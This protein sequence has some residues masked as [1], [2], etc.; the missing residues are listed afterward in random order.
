MS[1]QFGRLLAQ[2][3]S[4]IFLGFCFGKLHFREFGG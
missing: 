2:K 1:S 4:V 3:S